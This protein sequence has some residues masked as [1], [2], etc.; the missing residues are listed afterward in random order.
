MK[1]A[2]NMNLK[3]CMNL[4]TLKN[5]LLLGRQHN[6]QQFDN[7]PMRGQMLMRRKEGPFHLNIP[8]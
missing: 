3:M 6:N 5:A 1:I 4:N 2:I 7:I 8:N